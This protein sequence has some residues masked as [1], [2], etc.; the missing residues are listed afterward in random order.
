MK[1]LK[2]IESRMKKLLVVTA[3][4]L[5]ILSINVQAVKAD[6]MNF[7]AQ[8]YILVDAKTGQVLHEHN[9]NDRLYPASTTKI[10]TA[11]MALEKGNLDAMMV[12][13]QAAVFDIGRD[14]MNIGIVAGEEIRMGDL[15]NA[16]LIRSAN[17]TANIIAENLAPSRAEFME[18]MNK[19]AHE[20][21]ATNTN[22][23]NPSGKD[24]DRGDVNHLTTAS[25]MAK[26][27][28]H[29]MTIPKFRETVASKGFTMPASN[30]HQASFW[31]AYSNTNKLLL[32]ERFK[33]PLF[34]ATG[35]K[36]G[37]TDRAGVCLV[38]GG[39]NSEGME[40]ISVI[41][42]VKNAPADSVFSYT[43]T[44]LEYGFKN[45]AMQKIVEQ[46]QLVKNVPVADAADN[47]TLDLISSK[48]LSSVL[49]LDKDAWNLVSRE[50]IN[51]EITA[52]VNQGDILGYIE[53]ER[54]GILLGKVDIIA[55]ST[56]EKSVKA[57]AGHTVKSAITAPAW[58]RIPTG[59]LIMLLSFFSLRF[60]LRRVSRYVNARRHERTGS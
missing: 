28:R 30:K 42:G 27:A 32:F 3:V 54:N 21:G 53:Y 58:K 9:A 55:A 14:G 39:A 38:A 19:R 52:P 16:L 23:V 22:F 49:P 43:K 51:P 36:T 24:S 25:D 45:F 48:T 10:M 29:A 11:V 4:T 34:E 17:E 26:I 6:N 8:S 46:N 2:Y 37:Y 15:L 57:K 33:S 20:L 7:L 31:P 18:Q 1:F 5:S 40:L 60:I 41:L 47:A 35:I 13:S 50:N 56:I 12:A 59:I 44:L